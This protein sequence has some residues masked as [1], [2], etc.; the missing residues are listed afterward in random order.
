[1]YKAPIILFFNISDFLFS[2][3]ILCFALLAVHILF[4]NYFLSR[5]SNVVNTHR[6]QT[7]SD[8]QAG[9]DAVACAKVAS[10]F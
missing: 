5:I 6:D 10:L 8:E 3:P 2:S 1:M 9:A 7:A 4:R